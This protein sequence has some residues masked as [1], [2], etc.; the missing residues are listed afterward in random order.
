MSNIYEKL[1]KIEQEAIEAKKL[2]TDLNKKRVAVVNEAAQEKVAEV[3]KSLNDLSRMFQ[4]GGTVGK[5]FTQL[6]DALNELRTLDPNFASRLSGG[7]VY[8]LLSGVSSDASLLD[9]LAVV[10]RK[11]TDESNIFA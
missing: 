1:A 11:K 10:V 7:F 6:S 3:E 8:D 2:L 9:F 5:K 4:G